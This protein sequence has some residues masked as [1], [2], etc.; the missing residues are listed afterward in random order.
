MGLP[1]SKPNLETKELIN[2]YDKLYDK[3]WDYGYIMPAII[4]SL[5]NAGRC[6]RSENDRGVIVFLDQ[7]YTW[8]SYFKCFPNDM[9]IK[10]TK[11]PKVLIKEFFN[12]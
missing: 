9:K 1:L 8:Q 6:I 12:S 7:R 11:D 3:G 2:Y 5:Q 10:I 4:K